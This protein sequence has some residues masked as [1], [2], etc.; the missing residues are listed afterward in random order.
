MSVQACP[1]LLWG[2]KEC[3][4][5]PL[6]WRAFP[7]VVPRAAVLVDGIE[8]WMGDADVGMRETWLS[9][10]HD[11]EDWGRL[12]SP[13]ISEWM[14]SVEY[15]ARF[16]VYVS[17][18][19]L[20]VSKL[21]AQLCPSLCDPMDCNPPGSSVHGILQARTLEWVAI[22]FSRGSFCPRDWTQVSCIQTD[23]LLSEPPRNHSKELPERV[24]EFWG[25]IPPL[26]YMAVRSCKGV[27]VGPMASAVSA[28]RLKS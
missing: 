18:K 4:F 26:G 15:R 28:T 3:P 17:S 6:T 16:C 11:R 10:E 2:Q 21:I 25:I 13:E 19:G 7:T 23:S 8:E 22:P 27:V 1:R 24:R 20:K 9:T 5:R 14:G 12:L